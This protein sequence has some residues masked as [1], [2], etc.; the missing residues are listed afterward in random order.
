M[1]EEWLT[2]ADRERVAKAR[3]TDELAQL[4]VAVDGFLTGEVSAGL[5]TPFKLTLI[6]QARTMQALAERG[7]R[8]VE[9]SKVH[10]E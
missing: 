7:L 4:V 2:R 3:I 10:E 5:I 9:T 1:N 8:D 6:M